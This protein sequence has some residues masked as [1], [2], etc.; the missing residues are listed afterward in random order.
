MSRR[1]VHTSDQNGPAAVA[2][3][4]WQRG[5]RVHT[6]RSRNNRNAGAGREG[7]G[8]RLA[9]RIHRR[10]TDHR[11]DA[12]PTGSRH[13]LAQS[14]SANSRKKGTVPATPRAPDWLVRLERMLAVRAAFGGLLRVI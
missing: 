1:T 13:R 5:R 12:T 10:G 7:K 9:A 11:S 2:A 4:L 14:A 6:A 8:C 3:A